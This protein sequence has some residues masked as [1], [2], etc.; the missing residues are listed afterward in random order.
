MNIKFSAIYILIVVLV[1][2]VL[3][4]FNKRKKLKKKPLDLSI[5]SITFTSGII[6]FLY[7][8]GLALEINYLKQIDEFSLFIAL[9]IA[10][11]SLIS[12]ATDKYK[13]KGGRKHGRT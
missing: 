13:T 9:F 11:I 10:G 7:L 3:S 4:I 8:V 2:F 1:F 12:S 5:D 6:L